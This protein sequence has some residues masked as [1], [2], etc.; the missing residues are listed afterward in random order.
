MKKVSFSR[1][2]YIAAAIALVLVVAFFGVRALSDRVAEKRRR[3]AFDNLNATAITKIAE[4]G[5]LKYRYTDVMELNRKFF[6]GGPST[7]L[8]RFTG[9][10]K[11]GI[12]DATKIVATFDTKANTVR[13]KLPRAAIIENTVDVSTVKIW[14]IKRNIFVPITTELKLQE[15][16]DFKNKTARELELSGFLAE[17]DERAE[18]LVSSLYSG[19]GAKTTITR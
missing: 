1:A 12:P 8:V 6:V 11:A 2:Q 19:F 13:I 16:S 10:V 18:E 9:I 3:M 7:S 4:L 17:A 14:D 5:V 15:I